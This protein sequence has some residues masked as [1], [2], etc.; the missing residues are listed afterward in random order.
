MADVEWV[1]TGVWLSEQLKSGRV[2]EGYEIEY[3][4]DGGMKAVYIGVPDYNGNAY[5]LIFFRKNPCSSAELP[6]QRSVSFFS[7]KNKK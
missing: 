7:V 6:K 3:R 2:V 4:V 1:N 5:R